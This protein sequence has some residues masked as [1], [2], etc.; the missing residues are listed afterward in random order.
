VRD[1]EK[2]S[3]KCRPVYDSFAASKPLAQDV[4]LIRSAQNWNLVFVNSLEQLARLHGQRVA[5]TGQGP[6]T[7]PAALPTFQCRDRIDA[8][9]RFARERTLGEAP[10]GPNFAKTECNRVH[11]I[12]LCRD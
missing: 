8:Q 3:H 1:P 5:K 10:R 11:V 6:E 2:L 4:I 9:A 7:D 12:T